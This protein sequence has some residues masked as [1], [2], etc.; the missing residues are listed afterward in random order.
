M[1]FL[2]NSKNSKPFR[3]FVP[4]ILNGRVYSYLFDPG[5]M[6]VMVEIPMKKYTS[7]G[8]LPW[9]AQTVRAVFT[10]KWNTFICEG[11]LVYDFF[12]SMDNDRVTFEKKD[13]LTPLPVIN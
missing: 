4:F 1:K 6:S 9:A 12:Y 10:R 7:K 13:T 8:S 3:A 2:P 11:E 5:E